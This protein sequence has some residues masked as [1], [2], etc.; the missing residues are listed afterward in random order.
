MD[1]YFAISSCWV[2]IQKRVGSEYR[3]TTAT[4]VS[5][6]TQPKEGPPCTSDRQQKYLG[7][8]ASS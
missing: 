3:E 2:N 4:F 6:A 1:D 7:W 5:F 8:M